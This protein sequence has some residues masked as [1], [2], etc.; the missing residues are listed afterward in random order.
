[1]CSPVADFRRTLRGSQSYG[2]HGGRFLVPSDLLFDGCPGADYVCSCGCFFSR[3]SNRSM[4]VARLRFSCSARLSSQ[5]TKSFASR[6]VTLVVPRSLASVLS[7][8][9][10]SL[11]A[12]STPTRI[13]P[14]CM[15]WTQEHSE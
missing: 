15:A 11:F 13:E 6:T 14:Q 3:F 10:A 7:G 5:A 9:F 8:F 12:I 1:M 4:R 2:G